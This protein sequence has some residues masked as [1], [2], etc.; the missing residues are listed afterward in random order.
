LWLAGRI[1]CLASALLPA[2]LAV[3]LDLAF[4]VA[5][6]VVAARELIAA[7]NRRNLRL[8]AP[9]SLLAIGNLLMHLQA[10][11][12]PV[13][14][15]LGWRLGLMATLILISVI[16]GRI[17]PAF[18][19]NWLVQQGDAA[20][21]GGHGYVDRAALAALH[22]GLVIWTF[23]PDAP[24][25]GTLLLVAAALNLWRLARWRG[26][27]TLAEPLLFVLHV[28]YLWLVAGIALLGLSLLLPAVPTSAAVH[29]LTGGAVG[30]MMLAVMTRATR[31]HTGRTLHADART[32]AMFA[33]VTAAALARVAA[34]WTGGLTLLVA[35]GLLWAAAF[36]LF[37]VVYGPMLLLRPRAES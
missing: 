24:A 5:L 26:G 9:L 2:A 27:A 17:V 22:I 8:L 31:G 13:P 36:L 29:A 33:L 30:T 34:T 16:A 10:L 25:L 23:L 21:P 4:P 15:G 11:G 20:A 14:P 6:I 12:V 1:A 35:A 37:A 18:T 3:G 32:I 28:G 19:R 7:G